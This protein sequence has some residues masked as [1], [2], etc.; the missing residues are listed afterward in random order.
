MV[1]VGVPWGCCLQT[2]AFLSFHFVF[3]SVASSCWVI[4]TCFTFQEPSN[5]VGVWWGVGCGVGTMVLAGSLSCQT[6]LFCEFQWKLFGVLGVG[7][8]FSVLPC[9][10]VRVPGFTC[11]TI[12]IYHSFRLY[13]CPQLIYLKCV[14]SEFKAHLIF[15]G[16][17][18]GSCHFPPFYRGRS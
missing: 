10:G 6:L 11:V 2:S 17:L 18:R 1:L 14:T 5:A 4:C 9:L 12:L 16:A 3:Y 7:T 13:I 8:N 15:T